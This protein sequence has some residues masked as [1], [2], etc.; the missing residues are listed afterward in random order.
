MNNELGRIGAIIYDLKRNVN[1]LSSAQDL[2]FLEDEFNRI[3]LAL[4]A[5]CNERV[6]GLPDILE[7]HRAETLRF[8]EII[9]NLII[10]SI[11][12]K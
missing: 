11:S 7:F 3:A 12:K 2:D 8:A 10:A 4:G 5:M 6:A 1:P 9:D